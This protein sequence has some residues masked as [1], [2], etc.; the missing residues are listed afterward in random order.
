MLV[1]SVRWVVEP[2]LTKGKGRITNKD[3]F[4]GFTV[5]CRNSKDASACLEYL[6]ELNYKGKFSLCDGVVTLTRQKIDSRNFD[7]Q[8]LLMDG[9]KKPLYLSDCKAS[10]DSYHSS[11]T[12]RS[13]YDR[14]LL[15]Q[16]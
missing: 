13:V 4:F 12:Q 1:Y 11:L 3:W 2:A 6:F 10:I 16:F 9:M 14:N 5:L 8:Y 15:D 7:V